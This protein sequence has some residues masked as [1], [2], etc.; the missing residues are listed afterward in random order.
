MVISIFI[1]VPFQQVLF[2]HLFEICLTIWYGFLKSHLL[3]HLIL[4]DMVK[5]KSLLNEVLKW[6]LSL[7]LYLGLLLD[8][9]LFLWL[10]GGNESMLFGKS[11]FWGIQSLNQLFQHL[12][13]RVVRVLLTFLLEPLAVLAKSH[14]HFLLLCK[15]PGLLEICTDCLGIYGHT[16]G[17]L[18][19]QWLLLF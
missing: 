19:N 17:Y 6:L 3:P 4:L 1:C 13:L 18:L 10:T 11:F 15:F 16:I 9:E 12:L 2:F 8:T 14:V 7:F 5:V